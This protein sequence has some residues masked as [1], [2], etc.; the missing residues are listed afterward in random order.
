MFAPKSDS[1]KTAGPSDRPARKKSSALPPRPARRA[2]RPIASTAARYAKTTDAAI[3]RVRGEPASSAA[4]STR[5][6]ATAPT[7]RRR[8]RRGRW[9]GTRT[10][11]AVRAARTRFL[12]G[13]R[14]ARPRRRPP[15]WALYYAMIMLDSWVQEIIDWHFDPATGSP[16]W[17]DY[18]TKN[19]WDPRRDVKTFADLKKFGEF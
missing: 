8:D 19:G 3:I 6:R 9:A 2:T 12:D 13:A 16:F 17:L 1:R 10:R 14:R 18:A 15:T 5:A 4:R 7:C 11:A